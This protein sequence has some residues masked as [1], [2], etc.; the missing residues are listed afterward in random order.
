[1]DPEPAAQKVTSIDWRRILNSHLEF[2]NEFEI[3]LENGNI[4]TGASPQGETISVYEDKSTRS[5]Y[6]KNH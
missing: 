2:T 5:G 4:G 1:M 3:K 6:P